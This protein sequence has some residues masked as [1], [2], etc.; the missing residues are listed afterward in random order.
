MIK[1]QITTFLVFIFFSRKL[2]FPHSKCGIDSEKK[3][4]FFDDIS[5]LHPTTKIGSSG[6]P[7][8]VCCIFLS[9]Y[10]FA[11]T[12]FSQK[13]Q[14]ICSIS[15]IDIWTEQNIWLIIWNIKPSSVVKA[16]HT[17]IHLI[18]RRFYEKKFQNA[19]FFFNT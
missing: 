18:S 8:Y 11:Y 9:K 3:E 16:K 12:V 2:I 14:Y 17:H 1:T 6:A 13:C 5:I 15:S 7:I 4:I 10:S 19:K